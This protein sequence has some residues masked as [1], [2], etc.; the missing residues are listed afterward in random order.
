MKKK[1]PWGLGWIQ[2]VTT[3]GAEPKPTCCNLGFGTVGGVQSSIDL[4]IRC[5]IL[6]PFLYALSCIGSCAVPEDNVKLNAYIR[7]CKYMQQTEA[8]STELPGLQQRGYHKRKKRVSTGVLQTLDDPFLIQTKFWKSFWASVDATYH[9][10]C[11]WTC[12]DQPIVI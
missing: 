10:W 8:E 4:K 12:W 11:L 6:S 2:V 1:D 5:S 7:T 9:L 3:L